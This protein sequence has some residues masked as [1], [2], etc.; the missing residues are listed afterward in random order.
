MMTEGKKVL[1]LCTGN[2]I[3]SQMAEGLLKALASGQWKVQSAGIIQSYVHPL[4]I[5]VMDEIGIDIS[6]QTSKSMDPFVNEKFDFVITLCD[7]AAKFC[8]AFG[9]QGKRLHWP[10][11]DPAGVNGTMEERLV[12]F[13]RIRDGIKKKIEEFLRSET[14]EIPDAIASFKF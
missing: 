5:R 7:H 3:R 2:S 4:A 8:P 11:E 6:R 10:F 9:G 14:S 1:F 13:R 12:V